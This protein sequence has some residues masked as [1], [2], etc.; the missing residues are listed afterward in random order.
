MSRHYDPRSYQAAGIELIDSEPCVGLF[1]EPGSGKTVTVMTALKPPYL[2]VAPKMVAQEVWTREAAKWQHTE[3]LRVLQFDAPFFDYYR[4]VTASAILGSEAREIVR[5]GTP[6]DQ[7]F[8]MCADVV[9]ERY[10]LLPRVRAE[11]VL[12]KKADVYVVS[13]DHLYVLAKILGKKWPFRTVVADESTTFKNAD[14]TRSKTMHWL[15]RQ[16]LV[17]RLVLLSGTPSPRGIENLWAQVRLLDLGERLGATQKEF[18]ERFMVPDQRDA[19]R[20][21]SWKAKPG[22]RDKVTELISDICMSVRADVWR[23]T[24][25]PQVVERIVQMPDEARA[26]YE[27]MA[28]DLYLEMDG[29]EIT[30][31]Q[32]AVLT[33]KLLQIA[34]GAVLDSESTWHVVHDAKLDA[35]EELIEELDGEPLVIMYWFKSTLARLKERFGR[36]LATIKTKGFLDQFAAGNI[37]LLALQPGGAGHGL[38]G[39]QDGGHHVAAMDVFHDWELFAQTVSRLDRS[40]QKHR[41][42]VHMILADKTKDAQVGRVLADRGADQGKVMDALR[43]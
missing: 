10:E 29:C 26:I 16:G 36:K 33:N 13:R 38:D 40:G 25:P 21:F 17:T 4:K 24:E 19:K 31:A 11:D 27:K 18:R 6:E 34:S 2:V 28:D 37:P 32:A 9:V 22:A 20:I 14:S 15:R 5:P 39:L 12:S 43:R 23:E 1:M 7:D 3:H 42:T 41:V 30:A 8:L 35:L